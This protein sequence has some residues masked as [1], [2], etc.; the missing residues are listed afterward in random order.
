MYYKHIHLTL[1]KKCIDDRK[2]QTEN[3]EESK[4]QNDKKS[5]KI[6]HVEQNDKKYND[7]TCRSKDK[8]C[9]CDKKCK[10]DG[11]NVKYSEAEKVDFHVNVKVDNDEEDTESDKEESL[12]AKHPKCRN[13]E[14]KLDDKNNKLDFKNN[15]L[16]LLG[17]PRQK[18]KPTKE[19]SL[20]LG[21][22]NGDTQQLVKPM[23]SSNHGND[24]GKESKKTVLKD[25]ENE[26]VC[27]KT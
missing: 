8:K 16:D 20:E 17:S 18:G 12:G 22:S 27:E 19:I 4:S 6:S 2:C 1:D 7:K 21:L 26:D 25:I 23:T 13:E 3:L 5:H 11:N 9:N 24:L 10:C 14:V 15:E